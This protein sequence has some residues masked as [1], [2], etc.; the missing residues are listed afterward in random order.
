MKIGHINLAAGFRGGERQTGLLIR[1]LAEKGWKQVLIV[2]KGSALT[3]R[4]E[5]VSGLEMREIAKPFVF[6]TSVCSDCDLLHAHEAKAGQF[7]YLCKLIRGVPYVITRRVPKIPK[8]NFFTRAVYRNAEKITALSGAIRNN[9]LAYN[10]A[11]NIVQIPS[12][13]S[14]LAVDRETVDKLRKI[15]AGKFVIGHIGALVNYHKGQQYLLEAATQIR[16]SVPD[17]V[18]LFLGEGKDEAWF[19]ELAGDMENINFVGFVDNVGDYIELFDL[20][21]FPSLQEGLGS[22]LLDVMRAEKP[23]I[24]SDVDGIPDLIH[25]NENGILVPPMDSLALS[26]AIQ[27]MYKDTELRCCLAKRAREDARLYTPE[28]ISQRIIDEVYRTLAC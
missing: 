9:L 12:M 8:N 6:H 22:I 21:V 15:Y 7:A 27:Y 3:S 20:F 16:D 10:P 11:L 1:A 5:D 26:E 14:A 2:R 13:A 25:H 18:Y 4:L 24:A 23:I 28:L 19:N 17:A